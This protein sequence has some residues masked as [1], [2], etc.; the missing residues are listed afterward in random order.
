MPRALR[1]GDFDYPLDPGQIAQT[2]AERRDRARLMRLGRADRQIHHHRFADLPRLLRDNDLLVLNDT[3]VLPAKFVCRRRSGGRIDGLFLSEPAAGRWLV[4]LRNAG[5][6]RIGEELE[7][8]GAERVRL[9]L[10]RRLGGGRWEVGLRTNES[11]LASAQDVLERAGRTPLPP[12]IR[13]D[14]DRTRAADSIDR[15]RYQ[16]VY[17]RRAG[18]VAAP[19]AGLHFTETLLGALRAKGVELVNLTLHVGEGTFAPVQ[20]DDLSRH[21]MHAEWYDLPAATADAVRRARSAG[22]RVVAVGTTSVRVIEAVAAEHGDLRAANGWTDLF[23]YPPAEFRVTDALV[24]NFHLPR[25]TLVMLVAAFCS[26]GG[27]DGRDM[28]LHAYA[29]AA[30]RGYRFYSYGDAMLIE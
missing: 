9:G 21:R 10:L 14:A 26:P 18:A 3:R 11:P 4:L 17:A 19:T 16:T 29:E 20:D 30:R 22:R 23:L 27:T 24:T 5:C 15:E 1:A 28:I 6:C 12:Y 25:S 13:R 7:L 8:R 2:P